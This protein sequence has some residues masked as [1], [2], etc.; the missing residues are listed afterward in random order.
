METLRDTGTYFLYSASQVSDMERLIKN[1]DEGLERVVR[2]CLYQAPLM[3][4]L[5][6][7]L[8]KHNISFKR[9]TAGS[10]I[11]V[12]YIDRELKYF[13]SSEVTDE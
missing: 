10:G 4:R 12:F 5:T 2:V 13:V 9:E 6:W 11:A 8:L 3:K 1:K 7:F